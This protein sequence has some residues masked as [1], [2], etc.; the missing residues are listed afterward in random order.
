MFFKEAEEIAYQAT[1]LFNTHPA[2]LKYFKHYPETDAPFMHRQ[3]IDW[4][5]KRPFTGIRVL[6]HVPVVPNTLLKI[7]CLIEAGAEVTVTNPSFLSANSQAVASLRAA[8]V[9]YVEN[10]HAL[11]EEPFDLYFDCGAELYQTL[12]APLMGAVEL[13]ASGDQIYRSQSLNF[14]VISIDPTL[15]KQLETIFGCAESCHTAI[16]RL[17]GINPSAKTW[18]VFGFGKIGRGVAYFC[19]QHGARVIVVDICEQQRQAAKELG[20]EA[21]DPQDRSALQSSVA[22]ADIVVTATGRAASMDAYPHEWFQG[23]ILANMGIYDEFGPQ[24]ST[25][26][27]L[28][29]KQPINFIIHDPTPM[30]FIDPE[31]YMHNIA[32]LVLIQKLL[33]NGIHGLPME[34]DQPIIH[35]WCQYHSFAPEIITQ[36]FIDHRDSSSKQLIQTYAE[37]HYPELRLLPQMHAQ[38]QWLQENSVIS[39]RANVEA[40]IAPVNIE[41]RRSLSR[42]NCLNL[43]VTGGSE[44]YQRFIQ[45]QPEDKVLSLAKFNELSAYI[46]QLS[47]TELNCLTA[48]CFITKSDRAIIS[49]ALAKQ[50]TTPIPVDSEQFITYMVSNF[51]HILPISALFSTEV[52][53]LLTYAFCKNS[54]L[55]H[56]LHIEGGY[57]MIADLTEMIR[58]R[59]MTFQQYHLWYARWIINIAGLDG[60]VNHQ[61]SRYLTESV[62]DNVLALKT[63]LDQL[64][65]NPPYPV[66]DRYL[67]SRA[68]KLNVSSPYIAYLAVHMNESNPEKVREIQA[69][70]VQLSPQQQQDRL[71]LFQTQLTKT[72]ITPTFKPT[73][74]ATLRALGCSISDTLTLFTEIETVAMQTYFSAVEERRIS[75]TTPLS[76][77]DIA[78]KKELVPIKAYYD[79]HKKAP[80]LHLDSSGYLTVTQHALQNESAL[81]E[82]GH[83]RTK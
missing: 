20:L 61:G 42:L 45:A 59:D 58:T 43:L 26:E 71:H 46:Q 44:S 47:P 64:W 25:E 22:S 54:H 70:F 67:A 65:I 16:A 11:A 8:G 29:H 19:L 78:F 15:T 68:A 60:H 21:I 72:K 35:Q 80:E 77:R 82:S 81:S 5:N 9:R 56:M 10:L 13:T 12:G 4:Y 74:L 69:W 79:A 73:V 38:M 62:A 33:S 40:I 37:T 51:P 14:P 41:V 18:I 31:F 50:R 55:R 36:W 63:E 66:V 30:R 52:I 57:N 17:T 23:K 7:A 6:H 28:N 27:V 24:F 75:A 32:G 53:A 83:Y 39:S 1:S 49:M 76:F 3:L 2:L 34:I 48:S